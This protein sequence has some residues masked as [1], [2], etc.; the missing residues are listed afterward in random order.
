VHPF[1]GWI[2]ER[3]LDSLEYSLDTSRLPFLLCD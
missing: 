2:V 3:S 1:I